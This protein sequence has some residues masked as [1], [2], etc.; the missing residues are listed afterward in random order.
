M[1][2]APTIVYRPYSVHGT[3]VRIGWNTA[4][5]GVRLQTL[6]TYFGLRAATAVPAAGEVTL[7]WLTQRQPLAIPAQ[8]CL[9]AQQEG[10][11]AWHTEG[12]LYVSDGVVTV[13][14]DPAAGHGRGTLLCP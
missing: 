8:A 6:C 3:G 13:Q 1:R 10:L 11:H 5:V 12:Q 7:T 4:S 2:H 9:M 14:L